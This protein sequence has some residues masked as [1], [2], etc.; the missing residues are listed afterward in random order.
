MDSPQNATATGGSSVSHH[1]FQCIPVMPDS[2]PFNN[3]TTKYKIIMVKFA[4]GT[5]I[6]ENL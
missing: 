4:N 3:F 5:K 6:E 1:Y 2:E